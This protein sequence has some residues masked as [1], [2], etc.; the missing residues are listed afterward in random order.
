MSVR[1][2]FAPS[3][4]GYLHI[5]SA[6]SS[7][8]NYLYARHAGGKFL[9]RIE[10]T[11]LARSTEESTRSILEGL[12]WLG[13]AP[14]EEIVF[15]SNNADKHRAVALKL[16]DQGKA[17][18][19]FT[20]KEAPTDA[21][22]KDT[23][24][25]R[26]RAAGAEKNMR[27]N[28]YRDLSKE[29]S[30]A[31]AAAGEP[32]A[33]RLKVPETGKTSFEDGVYGLQE[34]EYADT[35]DLVLLRSDGHPLYNLAVVCDDIEMQITHV[36]RGQDHLTNTHKQI[37][38]YEALGITPPEF[39]HL[40]LIMAPNKGKLSKRKHGEVV[41]MTTYRD[42]GFLAEAFRNFLALLGWTPNL[43]QYAADL[44]SGMT[45]VEPSIFI[46]APA[47]RADRSI[48]SL[49]EMIHLFQLEDIHKSNAI[50]NFSPDDPR[51]W[52]DERAIWMNA[53]YIRTL[54]WEQ[55]YPHVKAELKANKLWREEY[56]EAERYSD[57]KRLFP[58]RK[59]G[60]FPPELEDRP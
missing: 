8:F 52:T 31:R 58:K 30:D 41:S 28:P 45:E 56:D 34:R 27:D 55:I 33:I 12:A 42:A 20:P 37:L 49:Q 29:E 51:K 7:L 40:P 5:G 54:V 25:D 24:K 2:R 11:D 39:A 48:L 32:F 3:P 10:D 60:E 22:V 46:H 59:Q 50:F 6:R 13:L 53:E 19:D 16:L 9:L 26:A 15:Q 43:H 47:E 36:I 35:E 21:G 4:T 38:I 18:R 57:W 14:D 17:Y 44:V 1:V 23:I